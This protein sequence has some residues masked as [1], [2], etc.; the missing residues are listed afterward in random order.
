MERGGGGMLDENFR[1][2]RVLDCP[3]IFVYSSDEVD[4]G[5]LQFFR[6]FFSNCFSLNLSVGAEV[7]S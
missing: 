4:S 7:G 2:W 5:Q 1:S 3:S 6:L